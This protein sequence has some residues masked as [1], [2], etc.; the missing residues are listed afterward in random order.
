MIASTIG[1]IGSRW[2]LEP[3]VVVA[4]VAAAAIYLAGVRRARRWP[5]ARTAAFLAGLVVLA[6]ATTSGLHAVGEE[7]LSVHMVQHLVL[8]L[9][10]P[11]LLLAGAPLVL[12]LRTLPPGP[13]RSLARLTVGPAGRVAAHP[14]VA[15]TV[16][17]VVLLGVHAPPVYD[18]ALRSPPIHAAEHV[19]FLAAA[20][21]LWV[22]VLAVEPLPHAP[23]P[24]LRILVVLAAMPPM[25]ALGVALR[26]SASVVYDGYAATAAAHGTTAL[27]DQRLAGIVMWVGGSLAMAAIAVTA[28]WMA[29]LREERRAVRAEG[30]GRRP[31]A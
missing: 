19:L 4:L 14:A 13:R 15:L 1:E 27:A 31:A 23:S 12:A 21:L 11:P 28:G 20:L 9:A 25:I 18:A 2:E 17:V 5:A 29:I 24:L 16:F 8:T 26:C 22:P 6:V 10:V 3:G 7:L 30:L